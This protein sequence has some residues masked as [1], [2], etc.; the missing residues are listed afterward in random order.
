VYLRP[1][2]PYSKALLAAAPKPNPFARPQQ[3]VRLGGDVP[4][5]MSKPSGCAFRT[6]CPIARAEC[7]TAVPPLRAVDATS[8]PAS[9]RLV[10][11]P[12]VEL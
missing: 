10:A 8:T 7:A 4:S 1:L 5:P 12:F 6:R 3:R 11:C 9:A 2:H